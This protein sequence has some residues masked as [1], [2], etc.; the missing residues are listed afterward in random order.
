MHIRPDTG[1]WYNPINK[2]MDSPGLVEET[3]AM[4]LILC[5][6]FCSTSTTTTS[7]HLLNWASRGMICPT[8]MYIC[9]W[10]C[11]LF[12][13]KQANSDLSYDVHNQLNNKCAK[14]HC[15]FPKLSYRCCT[16]RKVQTERKK[17]SYCKWTER[18]G[19]DGSFSCL[20]MQG[21]PNWTTS[22]LTDTECYKFRKLSLIL[23]LLWQVPNTS[24]EQSKVFL[25]GFLGCLRIL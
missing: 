16:C 24:S 5:F 19:C 17:P 20:L 11:A 4:Y 22:G 15:P 1:V 14:T 12:I 25:S 3:H 10:N 2:V 9:Y 13:P 8:Y 21:F 7:T 18:R 6:S 23:T